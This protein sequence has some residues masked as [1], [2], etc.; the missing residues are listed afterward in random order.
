MYHKMESTPK[1]LT[2]IGLVLEFLGSLF[3]LVL[4]MLF[5]SVL[6]INKLI[7]L[8][9]TITEGEI[10]FLNEFF[11]FI[12]GFMLVIGIISG[13]L[14][15]INFV[16]FKGLWSNKITEE[17]AIKRYNYQFILGIVYL[18]VN[19]VVGIVYLISG[20]Q[21]KNQQVDMPYTREGI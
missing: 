3:T 5:N 1:V 12:L 7:E 13:I 21:G 19:T 16:V 6:D 14:F 2:I 4:Y 18:F 11:P 9:P 10:E 15:S 8:D 20:H 17:Q